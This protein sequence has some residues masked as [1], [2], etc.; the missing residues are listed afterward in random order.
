MSENISNVIAKVQKLLA[1]AGNNTSEHECKV[2]RAVADK[3]I[4]EHRLSMADI[5]AKGGET[6]P[7]AHKVIA[8]G[9]KRLAWQE[10]ILSE[11]C[12]HYGG[13]FHYN[14][15]RVG[16]CGGRGGGKGG[17]GHKSYTVFAKQSDLAVIE[18]M[19]DYL[20]TQTDKLARWHTGGQGIAASNGF[21][22][23]CA[24]GIASQFRDMRAALVAE[25]ATSTAMVLLNQRHELSNAHMR[26]EVKL[27]K[28]ASIQ[29]GQ[30]RDAR[31]QGYAEGRK[32]SINQGLGSGTTYACLT[33][34]R[35]ITHNGG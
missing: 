15:F 23:G 27:V 25:Q 3:L 32:V 21:R 4:Q 2:A 22:M 1:L 30:D 14:S 33:T 9:G 7:F 20:T 10:V 16:G 13:A 31:N 18:Y 12:T 34:S 28:G 17:K 19:F 5:E 26:S 8:K 6:E 11:L 24:A 29:G 35:T